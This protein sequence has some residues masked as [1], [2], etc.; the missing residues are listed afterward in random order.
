VAVPQSAIVLIPDRDNF[1]MSST[2]DSNRRDFLTGRAAQ[3]AVR[4]RADEI[5]D[6]ILG[7]EERSVPPA[8]QETIRL[9]TR[10]MAC[11]WAVVMNPGVPRQVMVASDAL[12]FV[13]LVEDQLTV[14]RDDSD[15]ARVNQQAFQAPQPVS[16]NLFAF[17][18]E[19]RKLWEETDGAFDPAMGALIQ[20]W[21]HARQHSQIPAPEA[22]REALAHSG[23]KHVELNSESRTVRFF[24]SGVRFDFAA[25]GKGYAIDLA[26]AH[27]QEEAVSDFLVHGGHSSICGRGN[28]GGYYGWPVGIKNPLFTDQRY[29]TLLLRDQGMSTSGSNVQFFRHEGKRYGHLLDPRTGWPAMEL[30]SVTVLAPTGAQAEALSTAF[31][32]MG[33]DKARQYCDDHRDVGAILVPSPSQGRQLQPIVCNIP[34]DQIFLEQNQPR[35]PA[36]T[37]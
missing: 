2:P 21:R 1:S 24:R 18:E 3:R 9:E 7:H 16:E 22:I 6:A 34:A 14:Y 15:I 33:L 27:L 31:Y 30:L 10:A 29:A 13:H 4:H 25:I 20:L 28:H 37:E 12:D 26:A 11:Q 19:C 5:A 17:L 23:M 36:D 8:G 32:A 35:I